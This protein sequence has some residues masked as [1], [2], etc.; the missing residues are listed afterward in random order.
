MINLCEREGL[1]AGAPAQGWELHHL[2][3]TVPELYASLLIA[4]VKVLTS[5]WRDISFLLG[6]DG[7]Q[8]GKHLPVRQ[9]GPWFP[10]SSCLNSLHVLLVSLQWSQRFCDIIFNAAGTR[11]F[12][13]TYCI[14]IHCLLCRDVY[15][16]SFKTEPCNFV[17]SEKGSWKKIKQWFYVCFAFSVLC[18][19]YKGVKKED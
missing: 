19:I 17:C 2:S 12:L 5:V 10:S 15:L 9:E 1:E 18:V 4:F 6:C 11:I 7:L 3:L 16:L 14:C 13:T 8:W